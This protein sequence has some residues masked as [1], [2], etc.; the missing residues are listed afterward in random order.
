MVKY[1]YPRKSSLKTLNVCFKEYHDFGQLTKS[2]FP[3][4]RIIAN[5]N[6]LDGL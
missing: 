1:V 2:W 4:G 6:L 3:E 5:D